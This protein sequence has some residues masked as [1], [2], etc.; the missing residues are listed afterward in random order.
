M[1]LRIDGGRPPTPPPSPIQPAA[2]SR[3][4]SGVGS[5]QYIIPPTPTIMMAQPVEVH[6]PVEVVIPNVVELQVPPYLTSTNTHFGMLNATLAE[7]NRVYDAFAHRFQGVGPGSLPIPSQPIVH[8]IYTGIYTVITKFIERNRN[9]SGQITFEHT[10]EQRV[11]EFRQ[12][13]GQMPYQPPTQEE[14][15]NARATK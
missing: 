9:S 13:Q 3:D 4:S 15:Y 7:V 6:I 1:A 12:Q 14:W 2:G 5:S 8:Q 11:V 10:V